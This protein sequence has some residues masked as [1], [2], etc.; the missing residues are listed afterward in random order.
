[1][2]D[3]D[4]RADDPAIILYTSGSTG[5][6]KGV[7]SDHRGA[8]AAPYAWEL[9][10]AEIQ[11]RAPKS[12]DPV[13]IEPGESTT[14]APS[15][16]LGIPLF[17][18]MGLHGGFLSSWRAQRRVV[19]M[20]K[21]DVTHAAEIIERERITSFS[22]PPAM[23]GDLV[24]EAQ[25]T[26]RDLSSL[27]SV[28]GGGAARAPE[29]VRQIDETF[30]GAVPS[31]GWGMTETNAAGTY[32]IGAEYVA[33]PSSAGFAARP[34]R[35]AHRR[36]GRPA[37]ARRR[38]RRTA[39][40]RH[41]DVHRV[42]EPARRDGRVV[43]RGRLVPH[44]RRRLPRRA[45]PAVHRRPHQGPDHP[46]RREHRLRA[47]GGRAARP[48]ARGGGR[49]VR[50]ARRAAGRGRR[51]HHPRHA[52]TRRRRT[53]HVPAGP[54][55]Q[56]RGAASTSSPRPSRCRAPPPASC[57]S[58]NCATSR[59]P[60]S[61]AEPPAALPAAPPAVRRG[62]GRTRRGCGCVRRPRCR[63]RTPTAGRRS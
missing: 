39:G 30:V 40:A 59:S 46:R 38:A 33:N 13:A 6:P 23:T 32:L 29:Q 49:G 22:A 1:M 4:V 47:G 14:Y 35:P 58:V 27:A 60:T 31:I 5:H 17:H 20:T 26:N 8:L 24:R 50:R 18:V 42:L 56:A 19:C 9:D 44:R 25:R 36:R 15:A 45:G 10:G 16:L 34:G 51:R 48:P 41:D 52:R 55:R 12:D 57:S 28:G 63:R 54:P 53:A 61:A 62:A 3:V 43:R 7:L 11:L 21:W 2:P 37:A